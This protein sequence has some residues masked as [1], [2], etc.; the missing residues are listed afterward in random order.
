MGSG[1][2]INI[3]NANIGGTLYVGFFFDVLP[4]DTR[5]CIERR[6][7]CLCE[8]SPIREMVPHLCT[9]FGGGHLSLI[10]MKIIFCWSGNPIALLYRFIE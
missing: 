5:V 4:K 10:A 6:V 1:H 2:S 8:F 9:Y 3:L 7:V